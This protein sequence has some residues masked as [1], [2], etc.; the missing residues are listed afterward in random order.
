MRICPI[1]ARKGRD[2]KIRLRSVASHQIS[3]R[4]AQKAGPLHKH[5]PLILP[6]SLVSETIVCPS[7]LLTWCIRMRSELPSPIYTVCRARPELL[8]KPGEHNLSAGRHAFHRGVFWPDASYT[9]SVPKIFSG[10]T[11]PSSADCT[12]SR[13]PAD[14]TTN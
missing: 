2:L 1:P 6:I 14:M 3:S 11:K 4:I 8:L 13:G 9:N 5:V 7:R 12:T 10:G